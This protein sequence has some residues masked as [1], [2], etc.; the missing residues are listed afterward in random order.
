M[1]SDFNPFARQYSA[2]S[3][4]AIIQEIGIDS[5]AVVATT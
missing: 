3:R 2:C 1:M 5:T 4:G